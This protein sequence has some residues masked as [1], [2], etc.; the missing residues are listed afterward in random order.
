[1]A[2]VDALQPAGDAG[3]WVVL[4]PLVRVELAFALVVDMKFLIKPESLATNKNVLNAVRQWFE[5]LKNMKICLT[6]SGQ[7]LSS[8]ISP[9]F[10][11]CPFFLIVD[12]SVEPT[13]KVDKR[14]GEAWLVTGR[15]VGIVDET[16]PVVEKVRKFAESFAQER[17]ADYLLL[18]S[19]PGT[20]CS[21]I[22]AL[23]DVD[24]AYAVTEPTPLGAHDLKLILELLNKLKVPAKVILNQANLGNRKSIDPAD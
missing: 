7:D 20:H 18:D 4:L 13:L 5:K 9:R 23:I 24:L 16:G 2:A 15:S 17:S 3:G 21:V 10:G 1:V 8:P 22:R 12:T 6:S 14:G 19:A 11:R